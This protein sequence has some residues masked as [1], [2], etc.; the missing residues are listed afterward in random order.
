MATE[1]D[2]AVRVALLPSPLLGPA[3]WRPVAGLLADGGVEVLVPPAYDRIES[4][5]DVVRHLLRAVP[6]TGPVV[7]VPHSNAGL[8]VPALADRRDVRGTVFVD[9]RLPAR[10]AEPRGESE[11]REFL[12]SLA[13]SDGRL[14]GWTRWWPSA[15][16]AGLFPDDAT[17]AEVE[18]EQARL[19][20]RYFD[21]P[22]P[23]PPG[24]ERLPAAY[25][26]FGDAYEPERERAEER[27][28]PTARL[29][30][31]HLHQLVDPAGVA[32]VI[33]ELVGLMGLETT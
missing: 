22:V 7:L 31:R 23:A 25:V 14:P 18:A 13:G 15:E 26:S 11:F 29:D 30:G 3:V 2:V 10:E 16:L 27:G 21:A 6:A 32:R 20:L 24:W 9:A 8:Y 17:R 33:L 12:G 1:T 28:W 4:P 5:D 19:P